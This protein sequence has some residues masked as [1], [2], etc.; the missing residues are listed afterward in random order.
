MKDCA[1]IEGCCTEDSF[2]EFALGLRHDVSQSEDR[3]RH[4]LLESP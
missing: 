3:S 4:S 2:D 1:Q